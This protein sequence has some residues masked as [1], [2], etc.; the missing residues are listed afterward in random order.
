ME[1][2]DQRHYPAAVPRG[3]QNP[4]T[5]PIGSWLSRTAELDFWRKENFLAFAGI[6]T[7]GCLARTLGLEPTTLSSLV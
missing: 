7:S 4:G 5:L 3:E 1:V 2:S 6:R